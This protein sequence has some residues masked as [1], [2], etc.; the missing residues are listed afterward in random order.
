MSSLDQTWISQQTPMPVIYL[1]LYACF[2][3]CSLSTET[4][5]WA[6]PVH[7]K[8]HHNHYI[9]PQFVRPCRCILSSIKIN[10]HSSSP[11]SPLCIS[12]LLVTH[13]QR[14]PWTKMEGQRE[15]LCRCSLCTCLSLERKGKWFSKS[16]C[17]RNTEG[18]TKLKFTCYHTIRKEY[19][20][21]Q[22]NLQLGCQPHA[23]AAES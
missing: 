4:H 14:S 21:S 23:Q 15:L 16:M 2:A 11:A 6:L 9:Q 19:V 13:P 8:S 7:I 5:H 20:S 10:M 22:P 17:P 3:T 1:V 12:S 18:P